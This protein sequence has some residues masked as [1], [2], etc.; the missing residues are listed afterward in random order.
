[1]F[2]CQ[3]CEKRHPLCWNDCDDYKRAKEDL[4]ER[5]KAAQKEKD[6]PTIIKRDFRRTCHTGR[7]PGGRVK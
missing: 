5:K 3:Y 2:S 7:L 4:E 1:M 6:N